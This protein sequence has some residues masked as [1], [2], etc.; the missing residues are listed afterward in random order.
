MQHMQHMQH[1]QCTTLCSTLCLALC[2]ILF[3]KSPLRVERAL[4]IR[5]A[6]FPFPQPLTR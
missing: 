4:S 6:L 2:S 3:R 5:S 1:M